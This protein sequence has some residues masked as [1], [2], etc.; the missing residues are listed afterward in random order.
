MRVRKDGSR[1]WANI[2]LTALRDEGGALL[3]YACVASDAT[4]R[5]RSDQA[6]EKQSA[7]LTRS[8]TELAQFAYVASHDLNA[9][10]H[11]VRAFAD[12]L[13]EKLEGSLDEE[14]RDYLR[15]MLRSIDGMQNLIDGLLE[16]ARVTTRG[17]GAEVVDLGALAKD[18]VES[19][20]LARAHGNARVEVG[21]LPKINADPLQMRQLL[22]NLIA[23]GLKFQRPGARPIVRVRG[24]ATDDGRCE[25]V[26]S[27]NG[28]GFDMKYAER[29]FQP[30]QRL[31]SRSDYEGSGMGLAI[32]Q[33]IAS[34]HGGTISVT[35]RPEHGTE[36]KVL[37]PISQ[38]GRM[39]CLSQEKASR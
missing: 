33:K 1:F 9:P 32:C 14:G 7:A 23:N 22:Q 34:R 20:D 17:G 31:N 36:F 21:A 16:L 24:K 2:V 8:N 11:K 12:R 19:L 30:F 37:L 4:Q 38:E 18:V 3:G 10:L 39:E 28:I 35:S 27:D 6:I 26:V 13:N 5:R 29:V 25:L 15:R